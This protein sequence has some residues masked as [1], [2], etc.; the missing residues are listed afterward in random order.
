[1]ELAYRAAASWTDLAGET[2][3]IRAAVHGRLLRLFAV[4]R[5][6]GYLS[7]IDLT[8]ELLLSFSGQVVRTGKVPGKDDA[9]SIA[10]SVIDAEGALDRHWARRIEDRDVDFAEPE[11]PP[12]RLPAADRFRAG[13]PPGGRRVLRKGGGA[14]GTCIVAERQLAWLEAAS[15][16]SQM[17]RGWVAETTLFLDAEPRLFA[18]LSKDPIELPAE[19]RSQETMTTPGADLY[20]VL[21]GQV[22]QVG[23]YVHTHPRSIRGEDGRLLLVPPA[24]SEL[25]RIAFKDL[26]AVCESPLFFL[27][28]SNGP[29]EAQE[30]GI[31]A[32]GF[33]SGRLVE[34]D[35]EVCHEP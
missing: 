4:H 17:E 2:F 13:K 31:R 28:S 20:K 14:W 23:A 6:Q 33:D 10:A 30:R 26:A 7:W 29:K 8:P 27:I 9:L 22:H 15:A 34:C 21:G 19:A 18:V 24:P 1:V 35:L 12:P 32:Y 3:S 5:E 16:A 25:D 11:G